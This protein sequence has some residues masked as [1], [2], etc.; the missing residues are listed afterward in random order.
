MPKPYPSPK[1][2]RTNLIATIGAGGVLI[3]GLLGAIEGQ[4]I[5]YRDFIPIQPFSGD[6]IFICLVYMGI[7][8]ALGA[9]FGALRQ[10]ENPRCVISG[11]AF[12]GA[13]WV[14]PYQSSA[15]WITLAGL[16]SVLLICLI[17]IRV[18]SIPS[19]L[20][21]ILIPCLA[22]LL[23]AKPSTLIS[24]P[25]T[26]SPSD[27][28]NV[29]IV[30]IDT[31]R[32]DSLSCYQEKVSSSVTTPNIDRL[33]ANGAR[34]L[35]AY[36]QAPWT[37]P[38]TASLFTGLYPASHGIVTP[39]DPLSQALPTMASMLKRRGYQTVGF[40][41]NPQVS[42]TFG[43][44]NGFDR[45]WSSTTRLVDKS[46]G[47][48][49]LR[50]WGLGK[51]EK[52]PSRGVLHS[53]ADDVN[54]A[55]ERW[56]KE[57]PGDAPTFLYVQ[58]LDPHDPYTAPEDLLQSPRLGD[59]DESVLYASQELPPYPLEGSSLPE[60]DPQE[61]HELQRRY[62]TEIRFVDDR[63]GKMLESLRAAGIWGE[64]DYLII[65]SDHGEEFHEHQ[66]WQHGRSLFEEMIHVPLIMV[67]PN[68]P[69]G[70]V[71]QKPVEL[72]DVLPTVAAWTGDPP[73]FNQHG[74][75]LFGGYKK[76][77][78]FSHRPRKQHPIWSLR[79]GAQKVIWIQGGKEIIKL[80]FDLDADPN[81]AN[82]LREEGGKSFLGLH[83][84]LEELMESSAEYQQDN[85]G[86]I[87]LGASAALDL[88]QLGYI[89]S[90]VDD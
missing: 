3:G 14:L 58:Y 21:P 54:L 46:A 28:P 41:A 43:F 7:M 25:K 48:R 17:W 49:L 66:Q 88:E 37:R 83:A 63:L 4:W 8:G 42:P 29:V 68:I 2:R 57:E 84:R 47:V 16:A 27:L 78:A 19:I 77:G 5:T 72:V 52:Q 71:V 40:S 79:V 82:P 90:A 70:D 62:D 67:G 73:R 26:V 59:V 35:S 9:I 13:A 85:L 89:D 38:S 50:K 22:I 24:R 81:E 55:I 69:A 60:L 18:S 20:F 6:L 36:A 31:L 65:T 23:L 15:T 32:A 33:A 74:E 75:N 61:L 80:A 44:H 30:V 12:A 76:M 11:L 56:L 51:S 86:P 53:T 87:D 45:F 34:F 64:D 10:W 1:M 39:F